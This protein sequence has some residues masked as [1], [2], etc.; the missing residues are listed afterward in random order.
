MLQTQLGHHPIALHFFPTG[1]IAFTPIHNFDTITDYSNGLE[2]YIT[3]V[4]ITVIDIDSKEEMVYTLH[5]LI[6]YK[7]EPLLLQWLKSFNL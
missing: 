4:N 5:S 7:K 3:P 1:Q 2:V 6:D